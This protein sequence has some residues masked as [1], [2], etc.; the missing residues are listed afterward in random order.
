MATNTEIDSPSAKISGR[1]TIGY[2]D[3]L[4]LREQMAGIKRTA[5]DCKEKESRIASYADSVI[6]LL[7][8]LITEPAG[9][10]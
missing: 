1:I 2:A 6:K 7:D 4:L 10:S 3:A 8:K 5:L 9:Q